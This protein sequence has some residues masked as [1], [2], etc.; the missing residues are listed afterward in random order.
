MYL[1]VIES[2]LLYMEL[3]FQ[4]VLSPSDTLLQKDLGKTDWNLLNYS[5]LQPSLCAFS[6]KH[7]KNHNKEAMLNNC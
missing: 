5:V 4:E 7:D 6:R 3:L 2:C 1:P